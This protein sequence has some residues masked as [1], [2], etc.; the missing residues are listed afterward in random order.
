MSKSTR[1]SSD[2]L[3]E[4]LREA[5]ARLRPRTAEVAQAIDASI[6]APVS[7]LAVDHDAAE[8]QAGRAVA[9]TA[10]V[11]YS[12]EAIQRGGERGPIPQ[13]LAVQA[14]LAARVGGRPGV[15]VR[16]HLAGQRSLFGLDFPGEPPR[17]PS[18]S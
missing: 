4:I 15:V 7:D 8:Y 14:R 12:L 2:S 17:P 5:A 16:S 18:E 13:A 6:R 11:E 3:E 10:A 9:A 1:D